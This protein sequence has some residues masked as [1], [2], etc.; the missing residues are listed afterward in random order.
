MSEFQKCNIELSH[1]K[2]DTLLKRYEF[3][4]AYNQNFNMTA[5]TDVD[6][7]E[8]K[9]CIVGVVPLSMIEFIKNSSFIDV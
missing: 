8:V 5:M 1:Y 2:A 9:L 7:V 6:E 4:V 3:L